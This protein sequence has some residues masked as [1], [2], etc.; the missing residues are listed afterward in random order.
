MV[1]TDFV[2]TTACGANDQ[3][4]AQKRLAKTQE[5]PRVAQRQGGTLVAPEGTHTPR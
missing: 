5:G 3:G 1:V 4:K 2:Y